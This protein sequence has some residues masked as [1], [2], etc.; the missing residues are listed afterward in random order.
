MRGADYIPLLHLT[1]AGR[2]Y[3]VE[4]YEVLTFMVR[5]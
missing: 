1:C 5:T 2:S 3:H 4:I